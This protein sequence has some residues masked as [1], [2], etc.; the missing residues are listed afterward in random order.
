MT[1]A[2]ERP[3]QIINEIGTLQKQIDRQIVS[4]RR[5]DRWP[6]GIL[7]ETRAK[8]HQEASQKAQAAY[9]RKLEL[10]SELRYSQSL[11]AQELASFHDMH[12]KQ[13]RRAVTA[14]DFVMVCWFWSSQSME[15]SKKRLHLLENPSCA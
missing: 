13:T 5:S 8:Y 6:L 4:L 10:A 12:M 15:Y 2:L 3:R 9:G 7:D 1:S 11:A 14:K